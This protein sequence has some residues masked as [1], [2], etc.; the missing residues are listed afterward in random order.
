MIGRCRNTHEVVAKLQGEFAGA[1]ILFILPTI[2]ISVGT[3]AREPL[4]QG[5]E[6]VLIL[7]E[8]LVTHARTHLG[9]IDN[10]KIPI[11]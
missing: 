2:H 8:I 5:I 9:G 3:H 6:M 11:N 1:Q 10:I 4:G 7:L